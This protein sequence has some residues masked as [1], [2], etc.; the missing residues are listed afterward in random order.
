MP[1][2]TTVK[3]PLDK[4]A[5]W[6][7][8]QRFGVFAHFGLYSLLQQ[9]EW[10]MRHQSISRENYRKLMKRFNPRHFDADEWIRFVQRAGGRYFVLTAKHHDGFC[11]FDSALTDFKITNTPFGRDL[12]G[13]IVAACH[14]ARLPIVLY[15]SQ[16]DWMHPSYVHRP[17]CG[18]DWPVPRPGDTPD[19]SAYLHYMF[20]QVEE[21]CT[22]YGRIDGIW[23]DGLNKSD[24]EWRGRDLYRL[25]KRHQ[26]HAV[27]NDR[28]GYGDYYT[29]ERRMATAATASGY[30]VEA[31][32]CVARGAW[33]YLPEA[34]LRSSPSLI[35]DLVRLSAAGGN[36]LLNIGPKADGSLPAAW[37]QRFEDIGDWLAEYGKSIYDTHGC[38]RPGGEE[39]PEQL[40][41]RRGKT[42][43]LHLLRWPD[44]NRLTLGR[45]TKAPSSAR[46]MGNK[47]H[48]TAEMVNGQVLL[49]GL[50]AL[51]ANTSA[52]V[53]ELKFN[54]PSF[55]RPAAPLPVA[56]RLEFTGDAP[57]EVRLFDAPGVFLS[58]KG[59]PL[60][61]YPFRGQAQEDWSNLW[62]AEHRVAWPLRSTRAG[63]VE[64]SMEVSS[65]ADTHGST[66]TLRAGDSQMQGVIPTSGKW[67]RFVTVPLGR[68][69]LPKGRFNLVM[70]PQNVKFPG[71]FGI[72]RKLIL[73]PTKRSR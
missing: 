16:P 36:Y 59:L 73:K 1:R 29:P 9:H 52:S 48:L 55:L 32:D 70:T 7:A 56:P 28:A 42:L 13:Q 53:I 67:F 8:Q 18:K 61:T 40:Y 20:G 3:K 54:S 66:F 39:S 23:F 24:S 38:P 19:W 44:T 45:L 62:Q 64:V 26:P 72:V 12:V 10:V 25:I 14:R 71:R 21:L 35:A 27:V 33:C 31:C 57:L 49:K 22:K 2:Y 68:L 50:P 43:Y 63:W 11:L 46:L 69:R 51:P 60:P 65:G 6:F 47:H 58:F 15:Y 4:R 34:E 17:G 41:T 5:A 37:V 30:M